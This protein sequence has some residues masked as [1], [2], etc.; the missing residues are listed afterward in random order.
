MSAP[1]PHLPARRLSAPAGYALL[2]ALAAG[3]AA[4]AVDLIVQCGLVGSWPTGLSPEACVLAA[5]KLQQ[6]VVVEALLAA[7]A[8][9]QFVVATALQERDQLALQSSGIS[10]DGA[11]HMSPLVKAIRQRS[12]EHRADPLE[13]AL[14][15]T[16]SQPT[17]LTACQDPALLRLAVNAVRDQCQVGRQLSDEQAAQLVD[18]AGRAFLGGF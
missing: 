16:P 18:A 17:F 12:L 11:G 1:R 6:A 8:P 14:V 4:A 13:A 15:P 5:C 9:A 7:G 3:R 2:E 10:A